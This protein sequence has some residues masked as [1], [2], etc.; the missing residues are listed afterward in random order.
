MQ[1]LAIGKWI[2]PQPDAKKEYVPIPQLSRF[3]PFGYRV[4]EER[5]GWLQPIPIELDALEK[6]KQYLKQYSSRQVAAWLTKVTGREITHVGLLKRFK[7]EQSHRR[8]SNT[9]RQLARRYQEALEKAQ[10]W[11]KSLGNAQETYFDTDEYRR[12]SATF[13]RDSNTST[14]D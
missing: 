2:L 13:E 7:N 3:V 10:E 5:E 6:A 14:E 9:Y 11:E 12:I 4:D 1:D 8:K